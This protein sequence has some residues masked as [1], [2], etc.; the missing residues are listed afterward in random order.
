MRAPAADTHL[1]RHGRGRESRYNHLHVTEGQENQK[2]ETGTHKSGTLWPG[3]ST[4]NIMEDRS[5][6]I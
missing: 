1:L 2:R 5:S 4:S 6:S 3:G